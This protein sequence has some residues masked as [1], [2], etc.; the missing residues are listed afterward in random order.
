MNQLLEWLPLLLFFAVFKLRGIYFA[1]GALMAALAAQALLYRLRNGH[2]KKVHL[3]TTAVAL[4]LGGLTLGLRDQR[5]IEWKPTVLLGLA[6]AAF[7]GSTWVGRRPL[8]R[9][10]FEG[11]FP[12]GLAVS[13]RAWRALNALWAAWFALLAAANVYVAQHYPASVWVDFKVFGV[14]I[15]TFA[16]MLPQAFWL[17]SRANRTDVQ[18]G[19]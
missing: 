13:A 1:T 5:F 16:F 10:M 3:I 2:F 8:A 6:A 9:A 12:D 15:A 11:A 17:A 14:S 4:V 18:P 7:L 19:A